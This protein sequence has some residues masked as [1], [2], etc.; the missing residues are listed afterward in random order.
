M[1][2]QSR[3]VDIEERVKRLE[4]LWGLDQ[5]AT[6]DAVK[7]LSERREADIDAMMKARIAQGK[8]DQLTEDEIEEYMA[9]WML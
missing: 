8:T 4:E 3:I 1:S 2:L 7:N 9:S 5:R 6:G